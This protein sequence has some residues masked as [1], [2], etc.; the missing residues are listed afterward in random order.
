MH[1]HLHSITFVISYHALVVL[2]ALHLLERFVIEG[3]EAGLFRLHGLQHS[4]H[5]SG[6]VPNELFSNDGWLIVLLHY[7]VLAA[8]DRVLP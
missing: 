3:E 5:A 2:G 1:P 7:S 4:P 6:H 8:G